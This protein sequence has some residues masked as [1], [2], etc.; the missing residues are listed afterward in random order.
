[1]HDWQPE[2]QTHNVIWMIPVL[3]KRMAV[4]GTEER[5]RKARRGKGAREGTLIT[6][7]H[8]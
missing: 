4:E 2:Q 7:E 5:I 1:M 8:D 3:G 6:L